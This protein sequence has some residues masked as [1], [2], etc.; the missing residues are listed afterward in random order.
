LR[1]NRV[2]VPVGV[3]VFPK[4]VI[5]TPRSWCEGRYNIQRWTEFS[6]GGHFAALERPQELLGDVRT[7]FKELR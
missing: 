3:A 4:E 2:E 6:K 5:R 1:W 7:F